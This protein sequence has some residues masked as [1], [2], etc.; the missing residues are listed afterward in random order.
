MT[1]ELVDS[2]KKGTKVHI[3]RLNGQ[4]AGSFIFG[5]IVGSE[6]FYSQIN[7]KTIVL[8]ELSLAIKAFV[9]GEWQLLMLDYFD[10]QIE[11]IPIHTANEFSRHDINPQ[12]FKTFAEY[13]RAFKGHDAN[14]VP[15]YIKEF[16]KIKAGQIDSQMDDGVFEYRAET[17]FSR[18]V[19]S[20]VFSYYP[21]G[22]GLLADYIFY[23]ETKNPDLCKE[24]LRW[25]G[26]YCSW[27]D[28]EQSYYC[29][30]FS[31]WILHKALASPLPN[32]RAG[33][34]IGLSFLRGDSV[35]LLKVTAEEESIPGLKEEMQKLLYSL[36][37]SLKPKPCNQTTGKQG[38]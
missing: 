23:D 9:S 29:Y 17:D 27:M 18:Q 3:L 16:E 30:P 37:P 13:H 34:V 14:E 38:G 6:A 24:M 20:L 11:V 25:I 10:S 32:I 15:A 33:A 5:Y 36:D 28:G 8:D 12:R 35:S 2:Y 1:K 21:E 4:D 22:L 19:K 26:C 31:L 7:G